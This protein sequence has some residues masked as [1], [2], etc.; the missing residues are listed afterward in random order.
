V[1]YLYCDPRSLHPTLETKKA[2][3]LYFAGQLNGT[4]GYEEAGK[5]E[6]FEILFFLLFL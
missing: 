1:E 5:H 4:T 6:C 2:F 3:G